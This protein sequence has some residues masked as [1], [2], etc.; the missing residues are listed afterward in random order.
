MKL[1]FNALAIFIYTMLSAGVYFWQ[2]ELP[3]DTVGV[4]YSRLIG[5]L[6]LLLAVPSTFQLFS[7]SPKNTMPAYSVSCATVVVLLLVIMLTLNSLH[8]LAHKALTGRW[9]DNPVVAIMASVAYN[10]L[11]FMSVRRLALRLQN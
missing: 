7:W 3:S 4:F 8:Q 9:F 11:F 6:A 2:I 1:I 5:S 10:A